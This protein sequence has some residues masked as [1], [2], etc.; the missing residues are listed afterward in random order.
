MLEVI[1]TIGQEEYTALREQW[2]RDGDAFL[3][4]YSLTSRA[5]F[6]AVN[7][8]HEQI[9]RVKEKAA[10]SIPIHIIG[11]KSDLGP[12]HREVA[13]EEGR[14]LSGALG[15]AGFLETS[16]KDGNNTDE[17]FHGLVRSWVRISAETKRQQDEQILAA[18]R[19]RQQEA[20]RGVRD[21]S[22]RDRFSRFIARLKP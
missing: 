20:K 21:R 19:E 2:I 7:R 1:D 11:N 10:S 3:I 8:F 14:A 13:A 9:L 6:D 12:E 5:S 18:E 17:A 16:A 15:A 4:L 22:L